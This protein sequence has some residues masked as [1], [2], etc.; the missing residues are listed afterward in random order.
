MCATCAA[1]V[2]GQD[3]DY[4]PDHRVLA[5]FAPLVW[6]EK[7]WWLDR[8]RVGGACLHRGCP[9]VIEPGQMRV[10]FFPKRGRVMCASCGEEYLRITTERP[11]R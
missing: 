1:H 11:R 2:E 9:D 6:R 10:L 5:G 8:A 4:C 7:C 3:K